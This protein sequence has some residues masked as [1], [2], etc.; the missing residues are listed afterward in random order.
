MTIFAP[1]VYHSTPICTSDDE[2]AEPM[3]CGGPSTGNRPGTSESDCLRARRKVLTEL[4]NEYPMRAAAK[5]NPS[6]DG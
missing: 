4:R 2:R 5:A 3:N 6:G 1:S